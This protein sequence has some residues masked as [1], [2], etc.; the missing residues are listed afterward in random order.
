MSPVA[1]PGRV[2]RVVLG[3]EAFVGGGF[4]M[5]EAYGKHVGQRA[6]MGIAPLTLNT[7]QTADII[8]LLNTP[9]AEGEI[10]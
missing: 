10:S 2:Y 7:E 5:R 1:R 8:D 4:C 9:P 6:A 3:L